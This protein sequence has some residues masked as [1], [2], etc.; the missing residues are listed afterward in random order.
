MLVD[1]A[2]PPRAEPALFDAMLA[3]WR[4]QQVSRRLGS[5]IIDG[6]ERVVRRF[7]EATGG[8]PWSWTAAQL[9]AWLARVLDGAGGPGR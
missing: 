8:W 6:R 3:G 9:E 4:R 2:T 7:Q 5:S 1:G